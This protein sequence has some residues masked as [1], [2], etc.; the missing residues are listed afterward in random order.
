MK[1]NKQA[2]FSLHGC[3]V[4]FD[5]DG[6]SQSN[7]LRPSTISFALK[8]NSQITDLLTRLE[9]I[10]LFVPEATSMP[11]K[12]YEGNLIIE[13]KNPRFSYIKTTRAVFQSNEYSSIKNEQLVYIHPSS[14][15]GN[16]VQLAPFSYV[17]PDC[18]IEDN[19]ILAPGARLIR[20]VY[21]GKSTK[22]GANTVIGGTGFGIE[23]DNDRERE[24]IPFDGDPIKMP[25]FGGVTIGENCDIGSLN[26][27]VAGAI[28][29]TNLDSYVMTDDHVHIGH[30]CMIG[31][32]VAITACA[33]ISGSVTVGDE[34]W[35]GPNSS[36]MQKISIGRCSII[37]L[38]SVV[39]KSVPDNSVVAGN[40]AKQ[41]IK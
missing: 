24:V 10:I 7:D 5:V 2:F 34:S 11:N 35:I 21:L 41:I 25:H 23:R 28:N 30:N 26:T 36:L 19:C 9:S 39:R 4:D 14:K 31:R 40:P 16:S 3:A 1:F 20:S 29:P 13:T 12:C 6:V 8:I 17:G 15:I 27:I 18:I 33:E 22:I 37:G 32:G 38:G